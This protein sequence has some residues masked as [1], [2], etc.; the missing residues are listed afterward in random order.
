MSS[1][2]TAQRAEGC[3]I[4]TRATGWGSAGDEVTS[5]FHARHYGVVYSTDYSTGY[6]GSRSYSKSGL[7]SMVS[8]AR[9]GGA[10]RPVQGDCEGENGTAVRGGDSVAATSG[11]DVNQVCSLLRGRLATISRL[12]RSETGTAEIRSGIYYYN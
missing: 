10:F 4:G 5:N 1:F 6:L 3:G 12:R 8:T 7:W 9:G 2:I 11:R